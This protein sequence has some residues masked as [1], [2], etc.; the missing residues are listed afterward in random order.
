MRNDMHSQQMDND[1]QALHNK[2]QKVQLLFHLQR[3]KQQGKAL[4]VLQPLFQQEY[5]PQ[6]QWLLQ[7]LIR[8]NSGKTK[9]SFCLNIKILIL[10]KGQNLCAKTLNHTESRQRKCIRPFLY[11]DRL[12]LKFETMTTKVI[13]SPILQNQ[14]LTFFLITGEVYCQSSELN[15]CLLLNLRCK[16]EHIFPDNGA[17]M[18]FQHLCLLENLVLFN[19]ITVSLT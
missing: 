15:D 1:M 19:V 13:T 16:K 6:H 10:L 4:C 7:H 11:L 8:R 14:P 3:K 5:K 17:R 9:I 2:K 18:R 12:F